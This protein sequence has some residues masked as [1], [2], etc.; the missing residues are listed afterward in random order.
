MRTN[1]VE[2]VLWLYDL[3]LSGASISRDEI[4]LQEGISLATFKR[5]LS[6]IRCFLC[7]F[8]PEISLVYHADSK[9][10]SFEKESF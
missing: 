6:D 9:S 1:H 2:T 3:L 4:M 8:H 10:Y 7:E 5:Y